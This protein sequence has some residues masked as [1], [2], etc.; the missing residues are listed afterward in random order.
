MS[1]KDILADKKK[2]PLIIAGAVALLLFII[3]VVLLLMKKQKSNVVQPGPVN[4]T[5]TTSPA[6]TPPTSGTSKTLTYWG[7][8]ESAETMQPI[9]D[10]FEE[11]NPGVKINYSKQSLSN[12]ES[13]IYTRLQQTVS[14]SEPAPDIFK[15]HNTWLP[16]YYKY[17]APL[18][19]SIMSREDYAEK[20]YPTPLADF[21]A[22]DGK[23]YAIP[24]GIDGL[25]VYYNK[26]ILKKANIQKPPSDW[27]SFVKLAHDLTIRDENKRIIQSGLAMG[28]SRNI[29]HSSEIIA[30]LLL[31]EG[32][33]LMDET[34]TSISLNNS[35]AV[36]AFETYTSFA[37]GQNGTWDT[38]LP[39]D[40]EMFFQGKLAM[41]IAPSWR[42]F[43]IIIA[44][45]NI[46]FGTTPLPQLEANKEEVYYA[47]YWGEAVS[48]N[49][50]NTELAWKF[51]DF[52]TQK[53]QQLKMF[54]NSV[55]IGQRAFGEPYSIAELGDEMK[56][57]A[58]ID[59]IAKMAPYMRSWQWGD[60][61][62]VRASIED[63]ISEIA[64][65][66]RDVTSTLKKTETTINSKLAET[67]K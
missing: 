42:V 15:I 52:M 24:L 7:L 44:A 54:S 4:N 63:A 41:M 30:Y 13:R 22:K 19:S 33:E 65:R 40:L 57:K 31:L 67:N 26:Q 51:I 49:A 3:M 45:P 10:E 35:K 29:K 34:R 27:D 36:S 8:W 38:S 28:V 23:I 55:S 53:E 37:R 21:T 32:A 59:A 61:N 2:L 20:F 62:F 47:T 14:T 1:L 18:P 46:E 5:E 43:D 6:P 50:G 11:A 56:G 66:N 9:I 39:Q 25:M 64:E 17:L 16:K 48:K 12:Y 58:Y 60:E